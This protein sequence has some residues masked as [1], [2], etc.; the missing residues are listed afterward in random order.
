[1][2]QLR[3]QLPEELHAGLVEWAK[4][5]Q[6]SLHAQLLYLLRQALEAE[7]AVSQRESL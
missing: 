5:E 6:R 4:R 2:K 3:L 1:M 7:R